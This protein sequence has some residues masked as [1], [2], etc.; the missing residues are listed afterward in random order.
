MDRDA[1]KSNLAVIVHGAGW[2]GPR[3]QSNFSG[4]YAVSEA[5]APKCGLDWGSGQDVGHPYRKV[6]V[7]LTRVPW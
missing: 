1:N 4:R 3:G 7:M 6:H 5:T 2:D